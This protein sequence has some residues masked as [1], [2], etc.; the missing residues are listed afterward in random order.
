M[1]EYE[2]QVSLL[3]TAEDENDAY[4]QIS[5]SGISSGALIGTVLI[6]S[7][8]PLERTDGDGS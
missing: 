3:V 7:L 4:S 6:L 1:P 2:C 5:D 8:D